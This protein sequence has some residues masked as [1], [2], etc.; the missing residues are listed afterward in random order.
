MPVVVWALS[1]L[2][3]VRAL[4]R[5]KV[6]VRPHPAYSSDAHPA[7]SRFLAAMSGR[8]LAARHEMVADAIREQFIYAHSCYARGPCRPGRFGCEVRP[9]H[10]ATRAV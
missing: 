2:R 10:V 5:I 4:N 9:P 1:V 8:A 3:R 6:D 7:Q